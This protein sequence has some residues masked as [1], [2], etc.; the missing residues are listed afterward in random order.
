[1]YTSLAARTDK[2]PRAILKPSPMNSVVMKGFLGRYAKHTATVTIPSQYEIIEETGRLDN[3]RRASGKSKGPFRGRFYN[4]SDVYKWFEGAVYASLYLDQEPTYDLREI[5]QEFVDAQSPDGY[6]NTYFSLEREKER[7]TDLPR[8][9]ELYCSGHFIQAA[10]AYKRVLQEDVLLEAAIRNADHIVEKF[11]KHGCKGAPGHPEIEMALVELYR[12]TGNSD[13][14]QTALLF[15][16]NRGA[17]YAGGDTYRIDDKSF[18]ELTEVQ[19]HAVMMLYLLSGATDLCL[20][21]FNEPF[22]PVLERLWEN[23]INKKMY[24][25]GGVGSRH[26]GESFGN[27][28][29]LPNREA[30]AE[31][32][33]SIASFLWNWRMY[34]LSGESKYTDVMERTLY[35]GVISGISLT[36]TEY[37]YVNPLESIGN[38]QRLPWYECSC[39]PT[40]L[41]RFLTSLSNFIYAVKDNT[42]YVNLYEES[43]AELSVGGSNVSISQKTDY[44][45]EGTIELRLDVDKPTRL[46]FKLR[47][48]A[49]TSDNVSLQIDGNEVNSSTEDGYISI[50]R[51]WHNRTFLRIAFDVSPRYTASHPYVR[52]NYGKVAVESGP[53]VYCA[54]QADNEN[55]D[56]WRFQ[57]VDSS[58]PEVIGE[59]KGPEVPKKLEAVGH[60]RREEAEGSL[61]REFSSL[62]E[63]NEI[64]ATL[65]PY[66][67]WAN[68]SRGPMTVW[69]PRS[70]NPYR[71]SV[72]ENDQEQENCNKRS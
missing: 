72:N 17:G 33:A 71:N 55:H 62:E 14:L 9:H 18:T 42:L 48:P 57:I 3:F 40:N 10:L 69:F 45:F 54:E 35:N 65:I 68:R 29:E 66:Y 64:N 1:M 2:S 20:E 27:T 47:V 38:H 63:R 53:L 15:L 52:N 24:I 41:A 61:Y 13:Y 43:T 23:M 30:Y 50:S 36:G 19:G 46:L 11:L 5:A 8:M 56:V 49:W 59:G 37:F 28:Y 31:T 51:T 67:F 12:E 7:W 44:P 25:T 60:I 70:F 22:L 58:L 39:C 4:D 34:L 32:C 6:L 21:G 26:N 16:N